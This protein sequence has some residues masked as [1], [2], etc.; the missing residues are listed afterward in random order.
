MKSI[1]SLLFI[2]A[3]GGNLSAGELI[4]EDFSSQGPR[5]TTQ[6]GEVAVEDG[7]LKASQKTADKHICAFRRGQ[8]MKDFQLDVDFRFEGAKVINIG[9]DPARGSLKKKGHLY[10]VVLTPT[11]W[12]IKEHRDKAIDDS[13]DKV[14]AS[15]KANFKQGEWYHLTLQNK[16]TEVEAGIK[17]TG[18]LKADYKDFAVAKPAVVFRV[19]GADEKEAHFDN[20]KVVALP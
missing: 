16:G 5:W 6:F 8:P 2:A 18:S 15:G 1:L 11:Q 3:L 4:N 7:V 20:L 13:K 12:Q 19:G 10:S 9:F 14:H 17:G